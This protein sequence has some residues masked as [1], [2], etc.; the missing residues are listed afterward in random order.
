M[1]A[2]YARLVIWPSTYVLSFACFKLSRNF[3]PAVVVDSAVSAIALLSACT[4]AVRCQHC[5]NHYSEV[6]LFIFVCIAGVRGV[7]GA[8]RLTAV[9]GLLIEPPSVALALL[10]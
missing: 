1:E 9:M 3:K 7:A 4:Q 8:W 10:V 2:A 5:S 6:F